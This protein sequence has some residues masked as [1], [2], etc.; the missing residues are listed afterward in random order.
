MFI[1]EIEVSPFF[2]FDE[3]KNL[4]MYILI[5]QIVMIFLLT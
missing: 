4:L 5:I 2:T 1:Q 3:E